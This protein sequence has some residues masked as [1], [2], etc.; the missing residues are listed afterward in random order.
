M[1]KQSN[2]F[3][4]SSPGRLDPYVRLGAALVKRAVSDLN[5]SDPITFFE[6]TNWML[7]DGPVWLYLTMD[8]DLD[9]T[10]ML[11]LALRGGQDG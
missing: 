5:S 11:D 2:I 6:V 3:E 8:Y 10:D 7:T 1:I 9:G 4:T